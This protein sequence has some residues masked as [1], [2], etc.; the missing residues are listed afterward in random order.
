MKATLKKVTESLFASRYVTCTFGAPPSA[1]ERPTL[2]L[3]SRA[4]KV[5]GY[6]PKVQ[7]S[8]QVREKCCFAAHRLRVASPKAKKAKKRRASLASRRLAPSVHA[9]T[10]PVSRRTLF[11][12]LAPLF[13]CTE[14]ARLCTY[15]ASTASLLSHLCSPLHLSSP[16]AMREIRRE[17]THLCAC[18]LS[19]V[20]RRRR[21]AQVRRRRRRDKANSHTSVAFSN[22]Q[23]ARLKLLFAFTY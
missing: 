16:S 9:N 10:K 23:H 13:A 14:G 1:N 20:R 18:A 21:T 4:P 15:G 11:A 22:P 7:A 8:K 2:H 5:Q 3:C 19:R 17:R 12:S 6:A